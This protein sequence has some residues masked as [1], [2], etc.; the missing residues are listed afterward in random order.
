MC[1][2]AARERS[3]CCAE[4]G[5]LNVNAAELLSPIIAVVVVSSFTIPERNTV[6]SYAISTT[7]AS[8]SPT[9][10]ARTAIRVS[11]RLMG[12]L[13]R[14]RMASMLGAPARWTRQLEQLRADFQPGPLGGRRVDLEAHPAVFQHEGDLPA[15]T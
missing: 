7:P 14:K 15:Q 13:R 2:F 3:V 5:S 4:D 8:S 1:G 12:A 9:A 6:R 10:L 11:L